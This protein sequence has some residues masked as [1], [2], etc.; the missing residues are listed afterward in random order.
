MLSKKRNKRYDVI[1]L[2]LATKNISYD[3]VGCGV[4]WCGVVWCGVVV[5]VVLHDSI[6]VLIVPEVRCCHHIL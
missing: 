2:E 4:V 5:D 3:V 6:D 1:K